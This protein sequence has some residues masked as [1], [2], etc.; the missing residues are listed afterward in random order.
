LGQQYAMRCHP[1]KRRQGRLKLNLFLTRSIIRHGVRL[2][3]KA[4][5][6]NIVLFKNG[7]G[8]ITLTHLARSFMDKTQK[9]C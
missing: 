8:E 9:L 5:E 2:P 7:V 1:S 4:A 6:L 3:V